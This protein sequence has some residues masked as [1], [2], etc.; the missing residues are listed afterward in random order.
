MIAGIP[1]QRKEGG[2]GR[3]ETKIN[4][5]IEITVPSFHD[6]LPTWFKG[7]K[8]H[9]CKKCREI[10]GSHY[11]NGPCSHHKKH[12]YKV[13]IYARDNNGKTLAKGS[14]VLGKYWIIPREQ[15]KTKYGKF[16]KSEWDELRFL[17]TETK[18]DIRKISEE[19]KHN[20]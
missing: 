19:M 4:G 5:E 16:T 11:Y 7:I 18:V 10:G 9:H 6:N 8:K 15:P 13:F 12:T 20:E 14:L 2:Q 3:I 17:F 1:P